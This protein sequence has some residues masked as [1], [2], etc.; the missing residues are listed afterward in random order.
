MVK[1]RHRCLC[2][3]V[4][5]IV[6]KIKWQLCSENEILTEKEQFACIMLIYYQISV[7][8]L[9]FMIHNDS[10]D[11]E[12]SVLKPQHTHMRFLSFITFSFLL[13]L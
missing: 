13:L 11:A 12:S 6:L 2:G 1:M 7:M 5:Q 4:L 10:L 8:E 3:S 9:S